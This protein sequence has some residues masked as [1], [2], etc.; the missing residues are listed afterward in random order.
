MCNAS[1]QDT[2]RSLKT[3]DGIPVQHIR[4]PPTQASPVVSNFF[5]SRPKCRMCSYQGQHSDGSSI[6]GENF[7]HVINCSNHARLVTGRTHPTPRVMN[8]AHICKFT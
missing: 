7:Q 8:T 3:D 5:N 2:T 6:Y 4:P 1:S